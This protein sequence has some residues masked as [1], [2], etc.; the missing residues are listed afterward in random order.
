MHRLV[1]ADRRA[2]RGGQLLSEARVH[3]RGGGS[4]RGRAGPGRRR[5]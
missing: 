1:M 4:A 3:G 5:R 2:Q